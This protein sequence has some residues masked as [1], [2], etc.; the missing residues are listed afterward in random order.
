MRTPQAGNVIAVALILLPF[1]PDLRNLSDPR[2]LRATVVFAQ[3]SFEQAT[4]DLTSTDPATRLRAVQMLNQTPYLEAAV[5]IAAL[6][7]D[8]QD[9]V[10]LEAIAAELN[11]FLSDP[12]VPRKRV[13]F[14]VE[15]RTP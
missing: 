7:T 5:P 13:G 14:V 12:I 3:V 9:E 6:I 4:R 2:D 10:Q 11:I 8:P 1:L 15:V